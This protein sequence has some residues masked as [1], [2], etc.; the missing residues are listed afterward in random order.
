MAGF[1]EQL[2]PD[3]LDR[4]IAQSRAASEAKSR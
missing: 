3:V 2:V 1:G 4:L